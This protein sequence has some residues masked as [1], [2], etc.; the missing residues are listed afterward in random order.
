MNIVVD[1]V[2]PSKKKKIKKSVGV[3]LADVARRE[4]F[5]RQ[6]CVCVC[7][8]A[9]TVIHIHPL[10]HSFVSSVAKRNDL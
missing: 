2:F 8:C 9:T 5:T 1:L 3:G 10:R 7:M 6:I 4:I